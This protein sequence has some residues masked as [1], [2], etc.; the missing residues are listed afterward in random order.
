VRAEE[1]FWTAGGVAPVTGGAKFSGP[2]AFDELGFER[3]TADMDVD[4]NPDIFILE[5]NGFDNLQGET[6]G[7]QRE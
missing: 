6:V 2:Y 7:F 3:N 4:S 5:Y 1:S